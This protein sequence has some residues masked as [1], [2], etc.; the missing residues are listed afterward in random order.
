MGTA[1]LR[2]FE[3]SIAVT[4]KPSSS[5]SV[6]ALTLGWLAVSA[7]GAV[8]PKCKPVRIVCAAATGMVVSPKSYV[9]GASP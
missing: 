8:E 2:T 5:G 4:C 7:S 9:I 3:M 1:T 6:F